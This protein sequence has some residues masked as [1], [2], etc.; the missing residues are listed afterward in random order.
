MTD[1]WD[2]GNDDDDWDVD[3]DVLDAKL[4]LKKDEPQFEDEEDLALK[5]KAAMAAVSNVELAKKGNALAAKKKAEQARLE[6]IELAR[7]VMQLE[8]NMEQNL[9]VDELRMLKQ[10]QIEQADHALTN[11]LFGAVDGLAGKGRSA[12]VTAASGDQLVLKDLMDHLRHAK[13]VGAA[14]RNTGNMLFAAAFLKEVI[15]EC[16]DVI[17]DDTITDIIKTCNVIK[18]EK[19]QAAKRQPKGQAQKSKKVD[20]AAQAKAKQVQVET[21]GD[22][23]EYDNIDQIGA[24]YEDAFF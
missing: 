23:D 13:K 16:K 14:I 1:N 11:D 22:N 12:A 20:K 4:G 3:D 7:K 2:D 6:E 18:N 24:D 21:F 15:S 10:Q 9:S 19:V 17:D 5:E 8:S